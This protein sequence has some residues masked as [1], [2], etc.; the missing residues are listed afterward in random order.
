MKLNYQIRKQKKEAE[1][2][3]RRISEAKQ[4]KAR[5]DLRKKIEQENIQKINHD[6]AVAR[7]EREELELINRLQN[8]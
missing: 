5:D 3:R 1:D 2:R 4:K 7:M 6:S 8:T